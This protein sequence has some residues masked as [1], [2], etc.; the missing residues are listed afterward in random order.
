MSPGIRKRLPGTLMG[1]LGLLWRCPWAA[2]HAAC[3]LRQQAS[4]P[5][6]LQADRAAPGR[7]RP[8]AARRRGAG[9]AGRSPPRRGSF[10]RGSYGPP[11]MSGRSRA[12]QRK[13]VRPAPR[14]SGGGSGLAAACAKGSASAPGSPP[15]PPR[16]TS[17]RPWRLLARA[18]GVLAPALFRRWRAPPN[19]L[20]SWAVGG[21]DGRGR[22]GQAGSWGQLGTFSWISAVYAQ[23]QRP[24]QGTRRL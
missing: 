9:S 18:R 3:G 23:R 15:A 2:D 14:G 6:S 10:S 11:P 5:P 4:T 19:R 16:A 17:R 13:T 1:Q 12:E 7:P 21:R 22:G 24:V 20:R 8:A